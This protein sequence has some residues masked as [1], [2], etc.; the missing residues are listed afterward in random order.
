MTFSIRML[1]LLMLAI[2]LVGSALL[3]RNPRIQYTQEV[4]V[5]KEASKRHQIE[6]KTFQQRSEFLQEFLRQRQVRKAE[7]ETALVTFQEL[8]DRNSRIEP[9]ESGRWFARSYP[10]Y[11]GERV[12]LWIPESAKMQVVVGFADLPL[13]KPTSPDELAVLRDAKH[14]LPAEV[15]TSPLPAGESII[16]CKWIWQDK[17]KGVGEFHVAVNDHS[18]VLKYQKSETVTSQWTHYLTKQKAFAADQA[19][20]LLGIAAGA[21]DRVWRRN[22][23]SQMA[24]DQIQIGVEPLTT[25]HVKDEQGLGER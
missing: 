12:R 23:K 18:H 4:S 24:G 21:G 8:A 19:Q 6:L 9:D 25:R 16:E 17:K 10:Q 20:R 5:L 11:K 22:T 15:W 14:Y 1:L 2:A 3:N 13:S 7:F